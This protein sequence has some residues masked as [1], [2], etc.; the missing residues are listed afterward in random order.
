MTRALSSDR[1][2]GKP[3]RLARLTTGSTTPRR[4]ARPSRLRGASGIWM[5][6]GS[7][8]ISPISFRRKAKELPPH[9]KT[10]NCCS[11]PA[12]LSVTATAVGASARTV[13]AAFRLAIAAL[14]IFGKESISL[15][16]R[17]EL[18]RHLRLLLGCGGRLRGGSAR[19][20]GGGGDLLR[21][22][23]HLLHRREHRLR[24]R[25]EFL[26]A[27]GNLLHIRLDGRELE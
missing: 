13:P 17:R 24:S 12:C 27:A 19:L 11:G 9:L 26:A 14:N 8:K 3:R 6:R 2:Q 10:M 5:R 7:R 20:F 16:R 22:A 18:F 21:A 15:N 1:E 25:Q 4:L 23:S